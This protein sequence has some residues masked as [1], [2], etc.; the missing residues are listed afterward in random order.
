MRMAIGPGTILIKDG[1]LLPE[2]L[3]L[4]GEPFV[5]GWTQVN[6]L[7]G[8]ELDRRIRESGWTFFYLAG[9]IKRTIFDFEAKKTV[10]KAVKRILASLK[11]EKFNSAEIT[12]VVS[13]RFL[14]VPYTQ[15]YAHARHV[16]KSMFL[17][18]DADV[19]KSE[20]TKM[21]GDANPS[22][23]GAKDKKLPL[24]EIIPYPN[25]ATS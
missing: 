16:Q 6:D 15:V 20:Q 12:R 1:T 4:D 22:V 13:K 24:Q 5:T 23:V 25:V 21:S 2:A 19:H 7:D 10:P 11:Q 9:E 17:F 14:G 18:R 8:H 3:R